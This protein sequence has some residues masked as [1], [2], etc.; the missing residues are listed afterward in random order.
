MEASVVQPRTAATFGGPWN[1]DPSTPSAGLWS[2]G[3]FTF[4]LLTSSIVNQ[5]GDL[6]TISG[7]GIITSTNQ[8]FQPT[9]ATWSFS[10]SMG[11]NGKF[12]F[13]SDNGAVPDGGSALALLGIRVG[14]D[15]SLSTE[16]WSRIRRELKGGNSPEP[17]DSWVVIS[18]RLSGVRCLGTGWTQRQARSARPSYP[19]RGTI[20]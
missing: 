19:G 20:D 3:G 15:R 2:V 10:Q 14:R 12:I 11:K 13:S 5:G 1:F 4:E 7:T 8:G 16:I 9:A 18:L 17:H 6:L